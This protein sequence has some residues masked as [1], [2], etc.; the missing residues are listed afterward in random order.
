MRR[1][2]ELPAKPLLRRLTMLAN[3]ANVYV[4]LMGLA[5]IALATM[6]NER[7]RSWAPFIGLS[8][9][10]AWIYLAI[11][12]QMPGVVVVTLAYTVVWGLGCVKNYRESSACDPQ[13]P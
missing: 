11:K 1:P 2:H 3:L 13:A 4:A 5:A 12:A 6:G 8:A 9:Q 7:G 10:P